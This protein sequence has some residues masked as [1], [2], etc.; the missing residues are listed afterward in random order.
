MDNTDYN[1]IRGPP[2]DIEDIILKLKIKDY[3]VKLLGSS[4]NREQYY[5]ADYDLYS[6]VSG[7]SKSKL[8]NNLL[9]INQNI[10]E[11]NKMKLIEVKFEYNDDKVKFDNLKQLTKSKLNKLIK[12][13]T[14]NFI[15]Y[16]FVV[17]FNY[18][19]TELSIIYNLNKNVNSEDIIDSLKSDIRQL[20][21]E[22]N[23]FKTAKRLYSLFRFD[24]QRNKQEILLKLLNSDNGADYVKKSNLETIKNILESDNID[25]KTYKQIKINLKS[26]GVTLNKIESTI[27]E[28]DK[29]IQSESKKFLQNNNLI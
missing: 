3:P 21:K 12:M 26:L 13:D 19:L 24:N 7:I 4:S 18:K 17:Y 25:N 9:R 27:K 23:Y 11:S 8:V 10:K 5:Y 22:G 15:K 6:D 1:I 2:T 16:D 29:S 28:L 14:I 20:I